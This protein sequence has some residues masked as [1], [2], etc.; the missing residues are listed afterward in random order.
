MSNTTSA[1]DY[2]AKL[3]LYD[4]LVATNPKVERQGATVPNTIHKGHMFSYLGKTGEL[5]VRLP[6]AEREAFLKAGAAD[7]SLFAPGKAIATV[8][9]TESIYEETRWGL[10]AKKSITQRRLYGSRLLLRSQ[11]P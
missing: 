8:H 10:S 5:A 9:Y 6:T 11:L 1:E 2:A 3:A 7:Y 4:K